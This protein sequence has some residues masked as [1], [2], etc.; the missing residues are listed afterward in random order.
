MTKLEK[1]KQDLERTKPY[2]VDSRGRIKSSFACAK[3]VKLQQEI[4]EME[5]SNG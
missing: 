4:S 3:V 2:A 5:G 1:K